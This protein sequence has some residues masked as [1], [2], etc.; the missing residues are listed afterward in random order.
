MPATTSI[1][2]IRRPSM[3]TCP[4][5]SRRPTPARGRRAIRARWRDRSWDDELDR[6]VAAVDQQVGTGHEARCVAREKHRGSGD[7]VRLAEPSEQML[8]PG[9]A[10]RSFHVAE[11]LDQPVGFD[12][13]RRER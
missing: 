10:P 9:Y 7:L 13:A 4:S 6:V 1:W 3:R 8:R 12:R 2:R 5:Y 11:A